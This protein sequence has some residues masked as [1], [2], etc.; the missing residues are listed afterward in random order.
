MYMRDLKIGE[1]PHIVLATGSMHL[2]DIRLT[3]AT[4]HD[5]ARYNSKS[6]IRI[7]PSETSTQV[8]T[9][10]GQVKEKLRGSPWCVQDR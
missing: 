6:K 3:T 1:R 5:V 4:G 9:L 8:R 10:G 2:F 7:R